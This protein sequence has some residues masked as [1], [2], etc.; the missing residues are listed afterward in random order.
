M[1]V[2]LDRNSGNAQK[3]TWYYMQAIQFFTALVCIYLISFT[4]LAG[5]RLSQQPHQPSNM[6]DIAHTPA[7]CNELLQLSREHS[8]HSQYYVAKQFNLLTWNIYKAQY[9]GL[10]ADLNRLTN[11]AGFILL[12]EATQDPRL[13]ELKPYQRFSPGYKSGDMQTGV[14][15]L[16]RWPATAHCRLSHQE[17]WLQ[18][19]KATN[20]TEYAVSDDR[21]LLIVNMHGINFTLGT[22]AFERQLHD[23]LKVV[24]RHQ[25]PVIF[26]GDLN[27]WSDARQQLVIDSL[28]ATGLTEV[29]Y[30]DDKRTKAFGLALDQIWT[31]GVSI[32]SSLVMQYESSDHN[33]ILVTIEVDEP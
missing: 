32:S 16:S 5:A 11:Q 2:L 26:A 31:R 6:A 7:R 14:L 27:A 28:T 10:F 22:T 25:G 19:P 4:A 17:P 23:A 24:A 20:I 15:T 30:S 21:R 8:Y 9:E 18:T 12:Q 29:R 13:L 33:P 1:G 3:I